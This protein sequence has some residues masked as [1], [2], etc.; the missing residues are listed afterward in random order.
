V[1]TGRVS[2]TALKV[3]ASLVALDRKPGWNE[4]LPERLAE[5]TERL[6]LAAGVFG[7]GP[8]ALR[9]SKQGWVVRLY[10]LSEARMPGSFDGLGERKIFINDQALAAIDTGARQVLVLGAGFDTLCL[11][12][13]PRFPDL[14][15]FEVD[16]P[17]TSAAKARGVEREGQPENMTLVAAD[18]GEVSLSRVMAG[19]RSWD[20]EARSI[21]VAEGLLMYL[22]REDVKGLFAEVRSCTPPGSRL[23]FSYL[24][25]HGRYRLGN[26]MLKLI[27]E[28]WL[29]SSKSED[30]QGYIGP[31]WT[32]IATW[33]GE[34][35]RQ[36]EGFAVAESVVAG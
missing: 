5:L 31:G 20:P 21:V 33:D 13:A 28:P 10:S 22:S 25:D 3:A 2:H 24:N 23:A 18:L 14:S 27:G 34:K 16:H 35:K 30:L 29:S 15:F 17:S 11:R 12:L 26:A 32:V 19:C 36:L 6:V 7:Y 8:F 1:K 9:L 4:R